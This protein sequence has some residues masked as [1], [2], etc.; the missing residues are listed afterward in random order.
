MKQIYQKQGQQQVT[1]QQLNVC[2]HIQVLSVIKYFIS[3]VLAKLE[4]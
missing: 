4:N 1:M 3:K 2:I